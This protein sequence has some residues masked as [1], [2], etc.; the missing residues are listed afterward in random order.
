ML[1]QK[2]GWDGHTW[3]TCAWSVFSLELVLLT[4]HILCSVTLGAM[5]CAL[6]GNLIRTFMDKV[7]S[8][9]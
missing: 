6:G 2:W 5:E 1:L 3:A 4:I 7:P 9:S 8:E